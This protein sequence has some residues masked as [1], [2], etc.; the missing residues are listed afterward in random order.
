MNC[1]VVV[2]LC[3]QMQLPSF[4]L[5]HWYVYSVEIS[6]PEMLHKALLDQLKLDQVL[7]M[8]RKVSII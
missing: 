8:Q 6:R 4:L 3:T 1:Y 5:Q 2:Y 7:Q